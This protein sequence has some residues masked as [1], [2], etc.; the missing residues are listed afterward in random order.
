MQDVN[1]SQQKL[2]HWK[3]QSIHAAAAYFQKPCGCTP[4][5]SFLVQMDSVPQIQCVGITK[6]LFLIG[7]N[8]CPHTGVPVPLVS[9]VL[10]QI[11][12]EPILEQQLCLNFHI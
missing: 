1:G 2:E 3:H 4:V 11:H 9:S 6:H 12:I 8:V 10:L 5:S 7:I